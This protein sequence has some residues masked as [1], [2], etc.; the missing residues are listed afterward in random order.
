MK[1]EA[2]CLYR[3]LLDKSGRL[4]DLKRIIDFYDMY[5][6]IQLESRSVIGL[7]ESLMNI[8]NPIIKPNYLKWVDKY[9]IGREK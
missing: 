8:L 9:L 3:L 4:F 7:P 2:R 6:K 1:R 5:A